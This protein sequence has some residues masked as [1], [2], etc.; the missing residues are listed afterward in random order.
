MVACLQTATV[1]GVWPPRAP[2]PSTRPY[3][4]PGP[5]LHRRRP[6]PCD[7]SDKTPGSAPPG[8]PASRASPSPGSSPS[9][10]PGPGQESPRRSNSAAPRSSCRCRRHPHLSE[11]EDDRRGQQP[12]AA[13]GGLQLL[14]S[15]RTFCTGDACTSRTAR[16]PW[17]SS[18][19]SAHR[20]RR[21]VRRSPGRKPATRGAS[22][23]QRCPA[24]HHS[25]SK[26]SAPPPNPQLGVEA[27]W[28]SPNPHG[29]RWKA[30]LSL[31]RCGT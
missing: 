19:T 5:R 3:R 18:Q 28:S 26:S 20:R 24:R 14:C 27:R 1:A 17:H 8:S 13:A 15:H 4:A 2:P 11:A 21:F 16:H 23:H 7:C 29:G 25:R 30:P 6:C 31:R 10:K 22:A 9:E 12:L